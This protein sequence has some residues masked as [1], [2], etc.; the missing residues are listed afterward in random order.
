MLTWKVQVILLSW[1]YITYSVTSL[2]DIFP[3]GLL[4]NFF[5]AV[6]PSRWPLWINMK[7]NFLIRVHQF[8]CV[9]FFF[10]KKLPITT[11]LTKKTSMTLT[12]SCVQQALLFRCQSLQD[13]ECSCIFCWFRTSDKQLKQV[14]NG[15]CNQVGPYV[16]GIA[17]TPK[18][19]GFPDST[20]SW[21]KGALRKA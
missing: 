4:C 7:M 1:F 5:G 12:N 16:S 13:G 10:S 11:F 2:V 8:V 20:S 3:S 15:G 9:C 21:H 19:L 6:G 14:A 17:Q 18:I